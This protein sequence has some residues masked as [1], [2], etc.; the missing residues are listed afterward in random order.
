MRV[1][2]IAPPWVPVP[3]TAYGGTEAVVDVLARALSARGVDVRLFTVGTS[4]CPVP[5][6]HLFDEPVTPMNSS[7]PDLAHVTAAYEAL[8]DVDLVHDHTVLGPLTARRFARN[9]P[10]VTTIH[11]AFTPTARYVAAETARHAALIAIS[12]DHA[13][14][15]RD[16]PI[17]AVIPHGIDLD[18]YRPVP[19]SRDH[20]V[21]IGR[22]SPDQGAHRAVRVAH[23]AGRPLRI[24]A[25]ARTGEEQA[26]ERDRVLP[27]LGPDDTP[28]REMLL[29]ERV[30]TLAGAA[31]LLNTNRWREPFGLVMAEA[32]A[33]GTPV[34]TF[35]EGAAP[36]IVEHAR[37]GFVC[38]DERE[39]A[40]GVGR[41]DHI[42]RRAYRAA[43]RRRFGADRIAADHEEL[44]R[45]L[46]GTTPAGVL[47][48]A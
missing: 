48:G 15:A 26:Y 38:R 9:T 4:T 46:L 39:M 24:A 1:G 32:L 44:Y 10:L 29:P 43:A 16:V 27:L 23:D 45:S 6:E 40:R 21:F 14:A 3:P 35:A 20:L 11:H 42:D 8:A 22:M 47:R 34:L 19:T 12:H 2:I 30:E 25:E 36:E 7:L 37:T 5:R 28:P 33:C 31:A 17:T 13:R 18:R 41:L